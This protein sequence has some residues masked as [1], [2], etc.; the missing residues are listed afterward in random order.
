MR[1]GLR[2]FFSP[3]KEHFLGKK[4]TFVTQSPGLV[5]AVAS[6]VFFPQKKST[7]WKKERQNPKNLKKPEEKHIITKKTQNPH[8][9]SRGQRRKSA[10]PRSQRTQG[11]NI[12]FRGTP[13]SDFIPGRVGRGAWRISGVVRVTAG[14]DFAFFC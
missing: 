7:F 12:P 9:P 1:S 3:K 5:C 8:S 11:R 4:L 6:G 2:R 14:A 13:H 10:R